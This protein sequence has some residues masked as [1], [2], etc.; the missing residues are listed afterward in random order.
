MQ[1]QQDLRYALR[2]LLKRPAFTA[3]AVLTLAL[4]VG[5]NTAIFSVVNAAL[6]KP[7]PFPDADE[8]VSIYHSYPKINLLR[9]SVSAPALRYYQENARSFE[10]I[11]AY[12]GW[13]APQN[14]TGIGNPERVMSVKVNADFFPTLGI[15]PQLGRFF[16][17]EEDQP[18]RNKVVVLSNAFWKQRFG[19]DPQAV[20]KTVRLDGET[21]TIV[22]VM[23]GGFNFPSDTELWMPFGF[24]PEQ[25]GAGME[26][27]EVVARLKDGVTSAQ[28]QAE[29]E[30]ITQDIYKQFAELKAAEWSAGQEPMREVVVGNLRRPLYVLLAAV[31]CVLLIA[32]AN[33]ANLLLARGADRQRE[34]AVRRALGASQGRIAAQFLVEGLVLGALGGAA[35]LALG[36]WGLDVLLSLVPVQLPAWLPLGIDTTVLAFTFVIALL[37]GVIFG[38]VPALQLTH[39]RLFDALKEGTRSSGGVA[40]QRVRT[41]LVGVQIAV[42]LMLL[43]GAGLLIRT[44]MR[45]QS[46]GMGINPEGV[47]IARISLPEAKYKEKQQMAQ[48]FDRLL[49]QSKAMPGVKAAALVLSPPL[50]GGWTNSYQIA[51]KDMTPRPHSWVTTASP[52]YLK[53]MGIPLVRGRFISES[54]HANAAPV[55][56]IDTNVANSYFPGEDPIG[57]RIIF[58]AGRMASL[59]PEIV[60]I[61]GPVKRRSPLQQETKGHLYFSHQQMPFPENSIV[62][63]TDGDPTAL[64]A[65]LRNQVTQIDPEQPIF[66]VLTMSQMVD[67]FV[68]QPRFNMV[69]LGLFAGLALL[70]ASIGIYGVVSYSVAQRT[71][72][73]GVRMALG[74]EP[75]DVLK[76]V[77]GQGAK[78]AAFGLLAGFVASI[79]ATRALASML[80]GVSATDPMTFLAI[81]VLLAAVTMLASYI[82]ARRATRVDPVE[83][84]RYE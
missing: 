63:R 3:V 10:S 59:Q 18:G 17:K 46:A 1:L 41:V 48:F 19:A 12:S 67:R 66:D 53:V 70:L 34:I 84:L 2:T 33:I 71:R 76:M 74:A 21:Y 80:F 39:G 77:I 68:A 28:A 4:G 82:P 11:G 69:L 47:L 56:V 22:G 26:F 40:R 78:L 35:G 51:G 38:A 6:L 62:I 30:A 44:F 36:Y 31:V 32:C 20:G 58:E 50:Q 49:Q 37:S 64:V 83:A 60:G 65:A 24:T 42:A 81:A 72:E 27:M 7:F 54:D 75:A 9:A 5:L 16:A 79:A 55:V 13:Q 8:L 73:I 45:I 25:W 23:P 29:M 61:V 52:E 14:L 15:A 57:K 43:I